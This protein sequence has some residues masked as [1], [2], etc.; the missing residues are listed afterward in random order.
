M[1]ARLLS[2]LFLSPFLLFSQQADELVAY[3]ISKTPTLIEKAEPKEKEGVVVL[4]T[5]FNDA[6]YTDTKKLQSLKDKGIIRVELYYTTY[7]KS[8]TFDQHTLNRKRLKNLFAAAPNVLTQGGIE[9]NIIGQT[10][11]TSPEMGKDFFHGVVITY[12][13]PPSEILTQIETSF[14]REVAEGKVPSYAYDAY[15]KHE[16]K[17][18]EIDS[19][20][21][22]PR[23]EKHTFKAPEFTRGERYRIDYYT[24]NIK[25]PSGPPAQSVGVVVEFIITKEGKV[26]HIQFPMEPMETPYTQ[27]LLRFFRS[28]P[29]WQP[30]ILDSLSTE[31]HMQQAFE[32]NPRGSIIP[33]PPVAYSV[34]DPPSNKP[35]IPGV[36]YS[37]VRPTNAS[38]AILE[39]LKRNHWKSSA[40]VVDVTGSMAPY[41]AQVLDYLRL[42]LLNK[43]TSIQNIVFFNDGNKKSDRSKKVG[44]VGG[45]YVYPAT[46]PDD[47]LNQMLRVMQAGDGGDI[48][49][50]NIEALLRAQDSCTTCT[51]LVLIADNM[52]TP[53]DLSLLSQVRLPVHVVV[54]GSSSILNE[55]YLDIARKTKGTL[56][57]NNKD[58]V[59]LYLFEEG[60]TVQVGKE[61]Y[62]LKNNHFVRR[63]K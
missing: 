34:D 49:E 30:G 18:V 32:F 17:L 14:L 29:P 63:T 42:T 36:D 35:K 58:L 40:L 4:Q 23:L 7:R 13:N 48:Q 53:R 21:G 3:V 1:K 11:C 26:D 54:C 24:R 51:D 45:V 27:E 41:S 39:I 50:N 9:W 8:E 62:V 44:E 12:R 19:V 15:L 5:G 60:A 57:I 52:A 47:A 16:L 22:E 37:K 56:H 46:T 6:I 59:G 2:I 31:T 55:N 43:D 10:G 25:F 61:T 28:M 33:S 20:T 38:V